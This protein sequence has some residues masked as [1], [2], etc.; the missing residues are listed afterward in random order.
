M[1]IKIC[2]S[3]LNFKQSKIFKKFLDNPEQEKVYLKY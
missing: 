1:K 3:V 2:A